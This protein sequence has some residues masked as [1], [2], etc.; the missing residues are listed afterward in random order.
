MFQLRDILRSNFNFMRQTTPSLEEKLNDSN[1]PLEEYLKHDDAITCVKLMGKNTKKY[2]DSQ[3]VKKLIKYITEEPTEEDQLR[4]HKCPYI[5]YEILKCNCPF[6]SKRFILK[7]QEYDE[8]FGDNPIEDDKEIDFDFCK[9]EF[10]NDY[11]K[12]EEKL[13]NLRKKRLSYNKENNDD[14]N[15][16]CKNENEDN[17]E[18]NEIKEKKEN[19][20]S[21][22]DIQII[23]KKK[24]ELIGVNNEKD[25][26][27]NCK[28]DNHDNAKIDK[29]KTNE[30]NDNFK[31]NNNAIN[32]NKE[33]LDKNINKNKIEIENNIIE[34]NNNEKKNEENK[35]NNFVNNEDTI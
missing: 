24:V 30:S 8:E 23:N 21:N 13:K 27:D 29:E 10:E 1:Y 12:I 7:E 9:N 15:D 33:I 20:N 34:N 28:N 18:N 6:I 4:G 35:D 14:K 5:A 25:K 19:D 32:N 11:S 22:D 17:E 31:E 2:F 16:N 26:N 3:K